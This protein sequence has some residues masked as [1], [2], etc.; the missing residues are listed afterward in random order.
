MKQSQLFTK[1][2]KETPRGA[3]FI[4]HQLFLRGGFIFRHASGIYTL[5][6]LGLMVLRKIENLI[7]K[8]FEEIGIQEV[9]M[10]ILHPAELWKKTGR[11]DTAG[12]ELWKIKSRNEEDLVLAMTHEETISAIAANTVRSENELPMIVNQFQT[13][14]RDEERP[15][16]G[17][18]RLREFIMQDAYS[19]DKDEE[20]LDKSFKKMVEVYNK[21]FKRIELIAIPVKASTGLMGGSD[22][23]EFMVLAESGE[24]RIAICP[25]CNFAANLEVLKNAE[26]C[27]QC[28]TEMK[29]KRTI[30]VAHAFKLGTKYSKAMNILYEDKKGKK[31]FVQ[32]GCYGI[33]LERAMATI[34]E[35]Y[36]DEK[37]IIWPKEIAPFDVHLL[38]LGSKN[39]AIKEKIQMTSEKLYQELQEVKIEV[40][41][42]DRKEKSAGEKF[43]DADLIGIPLRIVVSEKTLKEDSVEI[44]KRG[45]KE[46]QLIKLSDL[47]NLSDF[48]SSPASD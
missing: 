13:K 32:M 4:S 10:S 46:I 45:E 43:A 36:H 19:F 42:D 3:T 22:S 25:K 37:G 48:I 7:R 27:P 6:P 34:V 39:E 44:K 29:I 17:L 8:E 47:K 38:S 15:R 12:K 24:D 14:I 31:H 35:I 33:G 23:Y 30:E 28:G 16:G 40:L 9:R 11:W 26:K 18:L 41:Y 20:N 5:L 2:T 1:T 21:I